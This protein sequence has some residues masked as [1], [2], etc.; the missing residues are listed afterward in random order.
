MSLWFGFVPWPGFDLM[1]F[2]PQPP[3]QVWIRIKDMYH[4]IAFHTVLGIHLPIFNISRCSNGKG[5]FLS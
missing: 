3:T 1:V 5:S 2:E 4:H